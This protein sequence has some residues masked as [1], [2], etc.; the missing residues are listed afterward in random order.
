MS[1]GTAASAILQNS[2]RRSWL[3][4]M[5]VVDRYFHMGMANVSLVRSY[6]RQAR[7]GIMTWIVRRPSQSLLQLNCNG[8]LRIL[9]KPKSIGDADDARTREARNDDD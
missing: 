1:I 5:F 2:A 8:A 9:A 6:N 4:A 3:G 7:V